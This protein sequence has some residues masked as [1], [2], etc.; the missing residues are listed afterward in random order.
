MADILGP[1]YAVYGKDAIAAANKAGIDPNLFVALIQS[2]SSFNANAINVNT[3]GTT[4]YGIAQLNSRYFPNA[5]SMTVQEQLTA[6]AQ[7]LKEKLNAASGDWLKGVIGYKGPGSA[8]NGTAQKVIDLSKQL[9][10][11]PFI[12]DTASNPIKQKV[13]EITDAIGGKINDAIGAKVVGDGTDKPVGFGGLLSTNGPIIILV[14]IGAALILFSIGGTLMSQA[15]IIIK[16]GS[17]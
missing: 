4:D 7:H 2:E 10:A 16:A 13:Q 12:A 8:N 9:G 17:K 15:P 11:D 1:G 14:A 3:N 5:M 6:A